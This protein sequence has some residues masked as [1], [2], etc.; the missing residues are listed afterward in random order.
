MHLVLPRPASKRSAALAIINALSNVASVYASF[1]YNGMYK[2]PLIH[3]IQIGV[4]IGANTDRFRCPPLCWRLHT[5]H[6]YVS[7]LGRVYD[8]T[9]ILLGTAEQEARRRRK[10]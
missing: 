2:I 4:L 8:H 6:R 10:A 9:S 3:Y 1:L 5:Q 7:R